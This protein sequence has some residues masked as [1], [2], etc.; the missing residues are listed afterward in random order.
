MKA[1]RSKGITLKC[2]FFFPHTVKP[3]PPPTAQSS[4]ENIIIRP[5]LPE[6]EVKV[7]MEVV[8]R[9]RAM[10]WQHGKIV[11]IITRGKRR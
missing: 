9:R 2:F 5:N 11:D 4:I 6:K 8:A 10:R 3:V 7:D 1:R